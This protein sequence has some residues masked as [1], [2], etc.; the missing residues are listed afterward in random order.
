MKTNRALII[1]VESY[2]DPHLSRRPGTVKAMREVDLRLRQG[3]WETRFLYDGATV[4]HERAGL[5]QVLDSLEWIKDAG[6]A[7]LMISAQLE[8]GRL[9]PFDV[10]S[11]FK[12]QS[13][14]DLKDVASALPPNSGLIVDGY[15]P[16]NIELD[17]SWLLSTGEDP[18][19]LFSEFGP[20]RFLHAIVVSLNECPLDKPLSVRTFFESVESNDAPSVMFKDYQSIESISILTP[21]P[22]SSGDA[23]TA[24]HQALNP[25]DSLHG[26][27]Y[28]D[29][30]R[31]HLLR[32]LGEGGI[33]QVYLA[34]DEQLGVKRAIKL[35][36][37]PDSITDDQREQIRGRMTQAALAAQT[38]S[39]R[40]HHVV[41]VFDIKTDHTTGLPFTVMEFLSGETLS[42]RLYRE[43]LNLEQVFEIG[44]TLVETMAVAHELKLIHRDLKPE[45]V[46]L[47]KR[48]GSDLFI[49]LLDFDLVK[50]DPSEAQ[51]KTQEGQILGTLEYMS[52]EQLKGQ[53]VD[54]R[55]DV[56]SLGA[57]LYE[58]F[59]GVRANPGRTQRALI[60]TLLDT[61]V[62]PL[63]SVN[64][65]LPRP[66]CELID[67]ALSLDAS[68]RPAHAGELL[69][70]LRSLQGLRP[71]LST[72]TFS[73]PR[74]S[75]HE[76]ITPET[77]TPEPL[78]FQSAALTPEEEQAE[79][80]IPYEHVAPASPAS[81][82]PEPV[83]KPLSADPTQ[84][85]SPSKGMT[86][87]VVKKASISS[88]IWAV[89]GALIVA[90]GLLSMR[91][92]EQT[93]SPVDTSDVAE[94]ASA[95][96]EPVEVNTAPQ[97]AAKE[98][99][100]LHLLEVA[101]PTW[102]AVQI[103]HEGTRRRYQG[104]RLSEQLSLFVYEAHFQHLAGDP[105][106]EVWSRSED[107]RWALTKRASDVKL[108]RDVRGL[109]VEQGDFERLIS[110]R[111][112]LKR[113][114]VLGEVLVAS[115]GLLSL[116][117][118]GVCKG[119]KIG[120]TITAL[121]WSVRGKRSLSGRCEAGGCLDQ[122]SEARKK[123]KRYREPLRVKVTLT[124]WPLESRGA[125]SPREETISQCVLR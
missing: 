53:P 52:P 74:F 15:I 121:S 118:K 71:S 113:D 110:A 39:E 111:P 77:I 21:P 6:Q 56:F 23:D 100:Q 29:N 112:T 22:A 105:P 62:K 3:G 34:Q 40:T 115:E 35:L 49:K 51:V 99:T 125:T 10:K 123:A 102:G 92:Q 5:N 65:K 95:Q 78:T 106:R 13:S 109:M 59:G 57:I 85:V 11:Q 46:M 12:Q 124:R 58:C 116:E 120:D 50:L 18:Q 67:R 101:T 14:L 4:L 91:S 68:V 45:N 7:L 2:K 38:L 20:T 32:V 122:L 114:P 33:G 41:R 103:A 117:A 8:D 88:E 44:L 66:L 73:T 70:A 104:G 108:W 37:I 87:E 83:D 25:D 90:G 79:T 28:L 1:G 69:S 81:A 72:M 9:F 17:V 119:L 55:A 89:A 96:G 27:R 30:G 36:K 26:G 60:Q 75:P 86:K 47:I 80:M 19:P 98:L 84:L 42:H 107:L 54:E 24:E 48:D 63:E 64:P 97:S 82:T 16:P 76:T 31:Y 93:P 61:G 43:P 94:R